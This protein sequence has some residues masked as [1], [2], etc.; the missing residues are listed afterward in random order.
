MAK[1]EFVLN[2]AGLIGLMRGS[3]MQAVLREHGNKVVQRAGSDDYAVTTKISGDRAAA[4]VRA[5][6]KKGYHD[7]L[8]NN[9]L[10]KAV[11]VKW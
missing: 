11:G 9:T 4:V 8:E 6:T 7:C 2:K 3:E 10:L 5:T 1:V